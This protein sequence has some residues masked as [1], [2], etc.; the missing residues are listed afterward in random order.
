LDFVES[1]SKDNCTWFLQ[2]LRKA[3]GEPPI[4]VVSSDA[5]KG[6]TMVVAEVFP[7]TD[8]MK[9]FAGKEYM[10]PA[11]RAYK[12]EVYGLHMVNVASIGASKNGSR[13]TIVSY[14]I[15]VVSTRPSSVTTSQTI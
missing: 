10:Y 15:E 8:Y 9:Q 11:T 7:H 3:I 12:I 5:C 2:Q 6:L 1:E 4:L 13:S 14:G